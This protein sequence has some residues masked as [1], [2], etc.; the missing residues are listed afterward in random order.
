[1]RK[2]EKWNPFADPFSE[3]EKADADKKRNQEYHKK[4]A[5]GTGRTDRSY[6]RKMEDL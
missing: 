4:L 1:M 3:K 5:K 6:H 2:R